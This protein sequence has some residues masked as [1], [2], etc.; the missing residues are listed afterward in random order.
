MK[1]LTRERG[2]VL[3]RHAAP[4]QDPQLRAPGPFRKCLAPH[5]VL[6]PRATPAPTLRETG[7]EHL[8]QTPGPP[9]C[10]GWP[11][12]L[13]DHSSPFQ[14]VHVRTKRVRAYAALTGLPGSH[15]FD[16]GCVSPRGQ[17]LSPWP[18]AACPVLRAVE[19]CAACVRCMRVLNACAACVR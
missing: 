17:A 3:P 7:A 2:V 14:R 13:S 11:P 4:R 10:L 12:G 16:H 18:P 8:L 19:V 6:T 1:L 9:A 5:T 15:Y